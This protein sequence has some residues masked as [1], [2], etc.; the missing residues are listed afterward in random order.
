MSPDVA[1]RLRP[2]CEGKQHD[3]LVFRPE[4]GADAICGSALYRRFIGAAERAGLRRVPF[5]ALRDS[6]GT[7]AIQ[8]FDLY[9]VQRF[10]GHKSITTT[11]KYLHYKAQPDAAKGMGVLWASSPGADVVPLRKAA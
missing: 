2:L 3:D 4:R 9:T 7:T 5:K 10:L 8:G 11:E 1:A 6:F